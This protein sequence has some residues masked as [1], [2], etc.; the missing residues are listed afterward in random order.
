MISFTKQIWINRSIEDVFDFSTAFENNH[1]WTSGLVRSEQ[2]SD[3]PL[4]VG[5]TGIFVQKFMGRE[6][7]NDVEVTAYDRPYQACMSSTSGPI[8]FAGCQSYEE[9]EGGTLF[10]FSV[11]AEAGGFFKVAE[12]M[13]RKQM[14]TQF[15][16]DLVTLKTIMEG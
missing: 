4:G 10:T 12:G 5:T 2:T 13:V 8:S 3:G 6:M 7:E 16:G 11:E 15:E 14:E 9:Q 1:L